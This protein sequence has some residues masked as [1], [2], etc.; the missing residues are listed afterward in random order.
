LG[1][2]NGLSKLFTESAGPKDGLQSSTQE[3]NTLTT[4]TFC[5]QQLNRRSVA[6]SRYLFF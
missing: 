5:K 4:S 1:D 6:V 2:R 3:A